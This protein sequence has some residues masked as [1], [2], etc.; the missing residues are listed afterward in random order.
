[1]DWFAEAIVSKKCKDMIT[2]AL[3]MEIECFSEMLAF[4]NESTQ[5][6]NPK[7]RR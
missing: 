5:G 7:Q 3:K 1:V 2:S 6:L 4:I